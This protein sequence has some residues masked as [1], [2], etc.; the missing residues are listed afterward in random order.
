MWVVRPR[1]VSK[2]ELLLYIDSIRLDIAARGAY[3]V[4]ELAKQSVERRVGDLGKERARECD[5]L[6]PGER[7][8]TC[9]C[10][11]GAAR[12]AEN[13]EIGDAECVRDLLHVG[14]PVE[15]APARLRVGQ[16]DTRS[17]DGEQPCARFVERGCVQVVA[18][19]ARHAVEVQDRP[20]SPHTELGEANAPPIQHCHGP[21]AQTR[22]QCL[23]SRAARWTYAT[24]FLRRLQQNRAA[25][26]PATS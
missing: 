19:P 18:P 16:A 25:F 12:R 23:L 10:L 2:G 9:K 17:F 26:P 5:A 14:G 3:V 11:R 6:A 24:G 21:F 13:R 8:A 22:H 4:E 1:L 15:D 20:A 7:C